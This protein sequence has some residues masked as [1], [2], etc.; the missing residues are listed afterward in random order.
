MF[1]ADQS[2]PS[3][4]TRLRIHLGEPVGLGPGKVELLARISATGSLSEAARQMGMSYNR[5]WLHIQAM[6]KHF[7]SPLVTSARGGAAGGGASLT[8]TG[9]Q[10]LALYGQLEAEAETAT[11]HTRR[12]L[13]RLLRL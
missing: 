4:R 13:H 9:R 7:K 10:V 2:P 8:E 5:A 6:N 1:E 11:E 3:A 12:Q